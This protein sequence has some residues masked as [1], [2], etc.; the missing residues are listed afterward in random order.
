[1]LDVAQAED[2]N[3]VINFLQ[4]VAMDPVVMLRPG[5]EEAFLA[6]LPWSQRWGVRRPLGDPPADGSRESC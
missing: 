6:P 5:Y 4:R 1:M 3:S 2:I